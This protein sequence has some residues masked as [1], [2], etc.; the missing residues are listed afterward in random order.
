M[1]LV[2]PFGMVRFVFCDMESHAFCE[3]EIGVASYVR[4]TV[5]PGIWFGFQGVDPHDSL[6]L[7]ISSIPHD[8]KEVERL[9]ISAILFDWS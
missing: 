3:E 1:N 5:P 6:V 2:V 8:P 7:N 4:I 9:P